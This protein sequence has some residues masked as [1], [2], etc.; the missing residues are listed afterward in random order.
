M[1]YNFLP[2]TPAEIQLVADPGCQGDRRDRIQE[3]EDWVDQYCIEFEKECSARAAQVESLLFAGDF[4]AIIDWIK[5]WQQEDRG[6]NSQSS[7]Y[8]RALSEYRQIRFK[9]G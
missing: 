3:P 5:Q 7:R 1:T 2:P 6:Y 9:S 8:R 4:D